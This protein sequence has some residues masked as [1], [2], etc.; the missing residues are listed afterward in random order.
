MAQDLAFWFAV[1][2]VSVAA[3]VL[4]KILAAKTTNKA[5]QEFAANS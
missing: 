4:V 1:A 3:S 5:F 2:A